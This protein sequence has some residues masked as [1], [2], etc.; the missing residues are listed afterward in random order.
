M[1]DSLLRRHELGL[2][3]VLSAGIQ[4]AREEREGGAGHFNPYSRTRRNGDAGMPQ[5]NGVLVNLIGLEHL[6]VLHRFAEAR[7]YLAL[8]QRENLAA[9]VYF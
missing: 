8:G 9:I 6:R 7:P 5:V 2:G 4:V 3:F 1:V